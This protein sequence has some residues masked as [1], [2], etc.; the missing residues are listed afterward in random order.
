M[1]NS[2]VLPGYNNSESGGNVNFW[3]NVDGELISGKDESDLLIEQI[4]QRRN[5][6]NVK[7]K[8]EKITDIITMQCI[9]C[10]GIVLLIVT[11]NFVK[12]NLYDGI[13]EKYKIR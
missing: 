5:A 3:D 6:E 2:L 4:R 10:I 1:E 11:I 12:K 9:M 8:S 7:R 13:I